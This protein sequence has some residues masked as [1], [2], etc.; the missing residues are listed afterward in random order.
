MPV[1][2]GLE[3]ARQIVSIFPQTAMVM[4]TM[5][6]T[7]E[8]LKEARAAGIR[9]VLCKS[10]GVFDHLLAGLRKLCA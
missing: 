7:E 3:A 1:M 9:D 6:H 10:D 8:L 4:F 5:H 2:N